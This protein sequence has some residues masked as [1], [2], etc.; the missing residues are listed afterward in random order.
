MKINE[1]EIRQ[2]VESFGARLKGKVKTEPK[3]HGFM[4]RIVYNNNE[5][6]IEGYPDRY[7]TMSAHF[8]SVTEQPVVYS[9]HTL[10]ELCEALVGYFEQYYGV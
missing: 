5:Y 4:V 2:I 9:D 3:L 8:Y 1:K 6:G 10:Y 7:G